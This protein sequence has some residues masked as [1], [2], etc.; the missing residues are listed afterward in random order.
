MKVPKLDE[1]IGMRVY[2]S[3]YP[4][5]KAKLR[6][7]ANDFVVKEV[8]QDG[9]MASPTEGE[10]KRER[11]AL[12]VLEKTGES[13]LDVLEELSRKT[14]IPIEEIGVAGLKDKRAHTFQF[15][16]IPQR[17]LDRLKNV[18]LTNA[19][20]YPRAGV[21]FHLSSAHMLGNEFRIT[22]R[23]VNPSE[24]PIL[25]EH[26]KKLSLFPNFFGYQRFGVIRPISHI[27][28][29]RILS[30]DYKGA[31]I[32]LLC[33]TFEGEPPPHKEARKRLYEERDFKEALKYFPKKLR[34]ERKVLYHLSKNPRDFVGA[35]RRL[36]K[37]LLNLFVEAYQSYLFNLSLSFRIERGFSLFLPLPGE[38]VFKYGKWEFPAIK[39]VG[40]AT[41]LRNTVQDLLIKEI[42]EEENVETTSFKVKDFPEIRARGWLRCSVA[43]AEDL[44]IS[45]K[46]DEL[47]PGK[48]KLT[49][50]FFLMK[51]SYATVFLRELIKPEDPAILGF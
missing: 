19:C 6:Q 35:L 40:Y 10:I 23:D 16:T 28:G 42:L 44:T 48:K 25:R 32:D 41:T 13:T 2:W 50:R 34:A 14:G 31:V 39:V 21:P 46:D 3:P 12:L 5:V 7:E 15:I 11:Y 24:T 29:K 22:L 9:L 45:E 1:F 26:A 33:R 8:L 36:G 47:N 51:G 17:F 43:L 4:P 37:Y 27:V 49:L 18:D 30:G 38:P 20:L